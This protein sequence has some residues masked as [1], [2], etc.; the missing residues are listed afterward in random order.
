[1][2]SKPV[3]EFCQALIAQEVISKWNFSNPAK[4]SKS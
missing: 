3:K 2:D 4:D 1:M